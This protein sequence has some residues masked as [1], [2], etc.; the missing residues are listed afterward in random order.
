MEEVWTMANLKLKPSLVMP[1]PIIHPIHRFKMSDLLKEGH[2]M[3]IIFNSVHVWKL[4]HV[5]CFVLFP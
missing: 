1:C 5:C 4:I 3:L 2:M